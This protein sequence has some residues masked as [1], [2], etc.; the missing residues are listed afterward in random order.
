MNVSPDPEASFVQ[1]GDA[2][3]A[4]MV[5]SPPDMM[6]LTAKRTSTSE[7][8][9]RFILA[10]L[11]FASAVCLFTQS[12]LSKSVKYPVTTTLALV[13]ESVAIT[14]LKLTVNKVGLIVFVLLFNAIMSSSDIVIEGNENKAP[15]IFGFFLSA[16]FLS[17][18]RCM[19]HE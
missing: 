18:T 7:R 17:T 10:S 14:P 3:P 5:S 9:T 13:G 16:I 8:I 19:R 2:A 1:I 4:Q 15:A 11:L 12:P 6:M